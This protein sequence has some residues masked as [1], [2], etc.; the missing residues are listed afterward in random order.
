MTGQGKLTRKSSAGGSNGIKGPGWENPGKVGK[1]KGHNA[2]TEPIEDEKAIG[3]GVGI[4]K[5]KTR[6]EHVS[7][8][9]WPTLSV[10]LSEEPGQR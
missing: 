10:D 3:R 9:T 4:L 1:S 5:R 8:A 6:V 2:R 7:L